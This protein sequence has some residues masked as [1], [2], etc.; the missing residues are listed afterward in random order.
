MGTR[1][2]PL[3]E[4][5]EKGVRRDHHS[6]NRY[7]VSDELSSISQLRTPRNE[8]QEPESVWGT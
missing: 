7:Q 5:P 6:L 8:H 4:E 3:R 1:S 2:H